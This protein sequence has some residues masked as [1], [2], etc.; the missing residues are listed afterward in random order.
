MKIHKSWFIM[1]TCAGLAA[2]CL[3]V[4][5]N[6]Y[7]AFYNPVS[8]GLGVLKGS[9]TLHVT[10]QSL[11]AAFTSLTAGKVLYKTKNFKL[12]ILLGSFTT[13]FATFLMSYANELWQF[14][15]LGFIRGLGYSFFG[16]IPITIILGNWFSKKTGLA[17]S[18]VMMFSGITGAVG[19]PLF[20]NLIINN[21][22]RFSYQVLASVAF[23]L[24]LPAILFPFKLRPAEEGLLPYGYEETEVKVSVSKSEEKFNF[25]QPSFIFF[26]LAALLVNSYVSLTSYFPTYAEF[27]GLSAVIGSTMVSAVM[28]GNISTKLIIGILADKIGPFRAVVV[29]LAVNLFS[30]VVLLLTRQTTIMF[31]AALLFGSIYSIGSVGT[32][33][34]VKEFFGAENYSEAYPKVSFFTTLSSAFTAS[35]IGY[36][37]D[38][39]QSFT[40][41]FTMFIGLHFFIYIFLLMVSRKTGKHVFH[42]NE[43]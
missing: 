4:I 1:L 26:V 13:C 30:L 42:K 40:F 37:F 35:I 33:L 29:M 19:S 12:T 39:T 28:M 11:V 43:V 41:I 36:I 6:C 38:F 17:T 34:L 32:P 24:T 23:V 22:W 5:G 25:L 15:I 9:F 21:G 18:L 31:A 14:Y 16:I 10:I 3:G 2:S 27:I 7:G 20:T 8:N